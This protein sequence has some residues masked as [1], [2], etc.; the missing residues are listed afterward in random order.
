M[1]EGKVTE[2]RLILI[3]LMALAPLLGHSSGVEGYGKVKPK[4]E[5]TVVAHS[6]GHCVCTPFLGIATS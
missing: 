1:D 4:L 5:D 2:V 6:G 3:I